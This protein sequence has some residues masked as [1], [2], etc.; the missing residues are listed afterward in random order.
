MSHGAAL[1]LPH[2]QEIFMNCISRFGAVALAFALAPAAWSAGKGMTQAQ[3][4][5]KQDR[6]YCTSGQATEDRATC[7]K[8]AAAAYQEARR[9]TLQPGGNFAQN[10]TE[11]CSAQPAEDREACMQRMMGAGPMQGS[12]KGGG[13]MRESE[14][15]DK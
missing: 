10:S 11:R 12:V 13:M 6:A 9:G 15:K 2:C 7:L 14:T 4:Q 8:E 5:Y 1:S 3:Q